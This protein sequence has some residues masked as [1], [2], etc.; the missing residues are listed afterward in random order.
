[1]EEQVATFHVRLIEAPVPS[2]R[3]AVI[4]VPE[5]PS[6]TGRTPGVTH[7]AVAVVTRGTLTPP[8]PSFASM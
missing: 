3:D 1:V 8:P 7:V 5:D 2:V 6:G 4:P